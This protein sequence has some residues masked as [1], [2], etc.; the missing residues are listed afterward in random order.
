MK[1][2]KIE[3]HLDQIGLKES[4]FSIFVILACDAVRAVIDNPWGYTAVLT[5][6]GSLTFWFFHS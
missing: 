1:T 5:M 6:A 2:L 4:V 3:Q